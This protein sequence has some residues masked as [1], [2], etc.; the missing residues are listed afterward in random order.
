MG[1]KKIKREIQ[2][3]GNRQFDLGFD[4]GYESAYDNEAFKGELFEEGVQAERKRIIALFKMLSDNQ[5]EHGSGTRAKFW[6]EA[7]DVVKIADELEAYDEE[8]E[9][10]G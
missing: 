10:I 1:M 2:E 9:Y 7:A 3:Y 5:L 6:K 8:G 4:A